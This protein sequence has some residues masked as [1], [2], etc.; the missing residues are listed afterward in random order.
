MYGLVKK[1]GKRLHEIVKNYK[2]YRICTGYKERNTDGEYC[3]NINT[4]DVSSFIMGLARVK[5]SKLISCESILKARSDGC[6]IKINY[7]LII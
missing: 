6:H 1:D 5:L 7:C 2:P 4:S 3:P